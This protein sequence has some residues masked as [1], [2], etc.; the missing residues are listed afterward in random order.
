[1]APLPHN[2]TGIFFVDYIVTGVE[3]TVEVR[4]SPVVSPAS[5]GPLMNTFFTSISTLLFSLTV[6]GVRFQAAG[7]NVAN[8]VVTSIDGAVYGTGGGTGDD[9][10]KALNFIGR[11]TAGR[12][13]RLMVFGYNGSVSAYRLTPAEN[14]NIGTAVDHL[15]TTSGCFLSIDGLEPIWYPYAN[16]LF[17]AYWQRQ[18][19]G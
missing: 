16:V 15:N 17:N 2:N 7:S 9:V 14:T 1:M 5:F 13:V 18:V 3:H 10:P 12:R 19:R 11:S 6:L 4:A 8:P